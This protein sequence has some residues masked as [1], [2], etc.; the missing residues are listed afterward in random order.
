MTAVPP[1][2]LGLPGL[3]HRQTTLAKLGEQLAAINLPALH[4]AAANYIGGFPA[5]TPASGEP[6]GGVHA[7]STV[8]VRLTETGVATDPVRETLTTV[9]RA[10]ERAT[11]A[12]H[13]VLIAQ[14]A[15]TTVAPY[16]T[17]DPKVAPDEACSLMWRVGVWEERKGAG[18]T[19]VG[20]V[21]KEPV[22]MCSSVYDFVRKHGRTPTVSECEHFRDNLRWPKVYEKKKNR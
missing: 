19:T 10:L 5:R 4:Q 8:P 18:P 14:A 6:G 12:L 22:T 15:L 2:H 9:D 17:G 16:Q 3:R 21:L 11:R 7:T 1:E 20:G 13:D